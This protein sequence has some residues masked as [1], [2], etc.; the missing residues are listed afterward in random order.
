[1]DC[2][3][4]LIITSIING[5]RPP[6]QNA[7]LEMFGL[8]PYVM[9]FCWYVSFYIMLMLIFPCY[10]KLLKIRNSYTW[11]ISISI[12]F[13][14]GIQLLIKEAEKM[15]K[16][17][18]SSAIY[19]P[20][21]IIGYLFAKY[22]VLNRM[23][24]TIQNAFVFYSIVGFLLICSALVLHG[25][26]SYIGGISIGIVIVPM[27]MEGI[28]F[29]KINLVKWFRKI[30]LVLGENS[31]NILLLCT[32]VSIPARKMQRQFMKILKI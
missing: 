31:M 10:V 26:K 23:R 13:Y 7:L 14:L 1:M 28:A 3:F 21:A 32:I 25:M 27:L 2:I 11:D 15:D 4:L 24:D 8:K 9:C 17:N 12:V 5:Y 6:F 30:L 19:L 16:Y 22:N 29:T 20:V 18:I